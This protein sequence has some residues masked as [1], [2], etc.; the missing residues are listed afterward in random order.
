[1]PSGNPPVS[2]SPLPSVRIRHV[3]SLRAVA[4]LLVVSL[5]LAQTLGPLVATGPAWRGLLVRWPLTVQAGR[6]G[7]MVFF[8]VSGFVI[9]RSFGGP[10]VGGARRFLIKRFCR[11]YPAFW[12]SLVVGFLVWLAVGRGWTAGTLAA[13]ATM[14]PSVFGQPYVLGV[15]WTLETELLFYGLCLGLYLV[16]R[17]ENRA[18]LAGAVMGLSG[19]LLTSTSGA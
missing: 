2:G 19:L 18:L 7:V 17:L 16:G 12:T 5:H 4:A 1:M 9:C 11:L 3:D 13:N 6:M 8:M 10:R 14:A 15:Y